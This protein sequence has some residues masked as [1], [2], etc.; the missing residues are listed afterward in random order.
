[1]FPYVPE[2][3]LRIGGFSL[4]AFQVLVFAAVV[5]GYEITVRRATRLGW[6]RDLVL[7][8][9]LWAVF[10]GFVGSHVFDTL[11]YEREALRRN[12][13]VLLELW[14][15]MSSYGGLIGGVLGGIVALRLKRL[16]WKQALS[17][18]DICAFAFPF[19]WIF[20]RTG[21]ALAHDHVGIATGSFLAVRFPD[22]PRYDL[23]LLELFW[24]IVICAAFVALDRKPRPTGF[25]V[26][27]FLLL[28]GPVRFA[29]DMLRVGD[30][31]YVGWTPG[32]YA[33][34]AATFV[35]FVLLARLKDQPL[36]DKI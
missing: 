31:R 32:Q 1:M 29:L 20:G 11:L 35:G 13:L 4:S 15:T 27:V 23:G 25:F 30:E 28:Y 26:A 21:C 16:S 3:V 22:G 8:L 19:A 18:F 24:T 10:L 5:A 33:S 6:D 2:P 36:E 9:V 14:G 7:S 12:P 34:I 17:F